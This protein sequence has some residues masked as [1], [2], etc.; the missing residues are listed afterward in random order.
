M[1]FFVYLCAEKRSLTPMKRLLKWLGIALAVP[2]LLI[3]VAGTLLYVPPVQDYAVRKVAAYVSAQTGM[4][5]SVGRLRLRFPLDLD[6]QQ[7]AMCNAGGD[8]LV[9]ADH[10][11]VDLD[12]SSIVRGRVGL[13]AVTLQRAQVDT[14]EWIASTLIRGRL[15]ELTLHD[16]VDLKSRH[17]ALS[18]VEA[19]GLDLDIALRDTTTEEDTTASAPLEWT[20][21]V[22]RA[23]IEDARV[24]FVMDGD[25]ALEVQAGV[26]SLVATDGYVDLGRQLYGAQQAQ[27]QAD[28]VR[29][30]PS[31]REAALMALDSLSL[32]A[33][34]IAYDG[35]RSHL[36]VP[37]L[38]LHTPSSDLRGGVDMD[39]RALAAGQGG[40]LDV[41]LD[42]RWSRGDLLRLLRP[43]L[44]KDFLDDFF[45]HYP[46]LPLS[47]SL[48]ASGNIDYLQLR[49]I[50]ATLPGSFHLDASGDLTALL[51]SFSQGGSLTYDVHTQDLRW[52]A[53][54]LDI[55][56]L[57]LPP[58]TLQG[59]ASAEGTRYDI[60]AQLREA[61]GTL[62][63]QGGI[64]TRGDLGY[65]VRLRGSALNLNHFLPADSLGTISFTAAAQGHGTDLLA[66]ATRM[67][68]KAQ[69]TRFQYKH[70]DLSGI[71]L[72]ARVAGGHGYARLH[73]DTEQLAATAEVD[74]LLAHKLTELTFGLD[75]S[76]AD[77]QAL[78]VTE[79]PLRT[80]MC[81][82]LDG[83]TDLSNHHRLF[84]TVTDIILQPGD[85]LFRPED[86]ELEA[87][88]T[89]DTTHVYLTSGDLL[90]SANGRTGYD[91]LLEQLAHF[92]DEFSRQMTDRRVN[93]H[94]LT[95]RLPQIDFH[96]RSGE[97]NPVHDILKSM[98]Y[99][100]QTAHLDLN[101]DP[102]VGINGGGH[103]FNLTPG[104]IQL[105][106][107]RMHVYQDSTGVKM[108]ARV[109]N[110]K[111]NPQITFD[112]RMNAYL[113][114]TGAGAT[115]TYFDERGRKGVDLGL[116]ATIEEE[117]FR[118]HLDPLN[119]IL[120]YR[121]F[122]LNDNNYVMLGR[123]N[124]VSADLDLLADDGT[125]LKLYSTPN[126]DALQDLSVSLNRFNLGELMT[127]L[128]YAPRLTGYLH[129]DA[130]LIQTSENLSVS[131]DLTANDMTFEGAPL[132][133]I[134]LQA[135]YLPEADGSHFVDGTL[136]QTGVPV[137]TFTGSYT[138]RETDG[139]LD[140]AATLDRL[141]FSMA[142]GFFPD[143]V[144]RLEGVAI[145]DIH[146]GGSTSR[147]LVDGQMS[148]S[149][150]RL[151]SEPYSLN[152]RFED[153]TI[154]VERSN[155]RLDHLRVFSTGSNPFILD[156]GID[157]ADLDR[158]NVNANLSA[159]DFEL[160]NAKKSKN[161]VAYGKVF[162]DF[163][164]MLR[165]T[166]DNLRM[167][168]RLNV[169]GNTDMTYVLSDSPLSVEDE[170]ADLVEF[171][172]FEDSTRV[173]TEERSRPMNMNVTM[174][175]SIDN[176]AQIH[177]L[178]SPDA[179]SY[180]D[181][182]G[183]GDL[184]MTYS[185]EKNLQLNGRYT[186]NSGTLK[187]TMMVIPLKEFTIKNGS[188]VEFRG[189]LTNPTLNLS[190]TERLRTTIT[191]N[192]HPRSV[193][194]D[195]GMNITQTLE[196]LG[197]EFTLDAPDDL[198]LQTELLTMSAEQRGRVAV[199]M[200]ATGMYFNENG[201]NGLSGQNALN[202]F[203]QSQIS[204]ITGKALKSVDLSI[205]VEQG[206]SAT[207][208][209]Q[210]D[211]SFRFAKRFWGNRVS[212]IVGGRVSSG[213]NV[214]NTGET[215][216]DNLSVEYRLDKSATRYVKLF[217][218]KNNESLLDG[219]VI[220]MGGGLV[221]RRKTNKLGEL[222]LFRKEPKKEK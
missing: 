144:A 103:V 184:T 13:D 194:F 21:D 151:V 26:R 131:A 91:Q 66:H 85:T 154:R 123:G 90:L 108:D 95:A 7:L 88:L 200:L 29:L 20:I 222:F 201:S 101:L 183:G 112:A 99:G 84:G 175:V 35:E 40:G 186:I 134:G 109:R 60:D 6:V 107:L 120:A 133:Q 152:L 68:A 221:L 105:D 190:A 198:S 213:A 76:H 202:A 189:S 10:A 58:M 206:T 36:A 62:N 111:R 70:I 3:L 47:V 45:R 180:V 106:T 38:A 166:L 11:L 1:A 137:A 97:H 104:A 18:D 142:N 17:V 128:P 187:Y 136:M 65:D 28:S 153:D 126:E 116:L 155:L 9:A 89:P 14:R 160:I 63:V 168:G 32:T 122:H 146:V 51:D 177:C 41:R 127:V 165:G 56:G 143:A 130:H 209:T 87:E 208:S 169:L 195:V 156:G 30:W 44:P 42:T 205:G 179:T 162:V 22:E 218:D 75:L 2:L 33:D 214:E 170:L 178:L 50:N 148:T 83:T 100:F 12:L 59:N 43:W 93:T 27:L 98:G 81:L 25:S 199:T 34:S 197:L 174:S 161:S 212:V 141:P 113:L 150:L 185:P 207:G 74:A 171:V 57:R 211:Y 115:L 80:S 124:R 172:D 188:Y 39:F 158:I 216:I 139:L 4:D 219:E 176:A 92:T 159:S 77:L 79:E 118:L 119:P 102:L 71:Q 132:G 147:P 110:G 196:N 163:N 37:S 78:G 117:G 48:A 69:L 129:G 5:V 24:R 73:S 54:W 167:F 46:D 138:P 53:A 220:E 191:E 94:E 82:H 140:V 72:A 19:R 164:A 86:I 67:D 52:V 181:L 16:D 31:G 173:L 8:T 203:L 182:E 215:L 217:Y 157:F 15:E 23:A 96:L 121:T 204:N 114:P 145:G 125:G 149:G 210:T 64:D 55:R 193:N 61:S 49:R 135:V 192:D